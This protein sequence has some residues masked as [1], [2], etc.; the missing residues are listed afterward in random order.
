MFHRW[1]LPGG[2]GSGK[3]L[4]SNLPN[5]Q[6]LKIKEE[7]HSATRWCTWFL[8]LFPYFIDLSASLLISSLWA[9]EVQNY[10]SGL[11]KWKITKVG[12]C[13]GP[14]HSHVWF[15]LFC[16]CF[17]CMNQSTQT[18]LIVLFAVLLLVIWDCVLNKCTND[19]PVR[20]LLN[21]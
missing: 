9:G 11:V 14:R 21:C 18:V 20:H 4:P 6:W 15:N 19:D 1:H 5:L 10:Q 17:G 12:W 7:K 8:S 16:C 3:P 2:G 13:S